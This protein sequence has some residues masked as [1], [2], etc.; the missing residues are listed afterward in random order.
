MEQCDFYVLPKF[1]LEGYARNQASISIN[2]LRKLTAPKKYAE[3][4][5]E[6]QQ[7]YKEQQNHRSDII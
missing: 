2:P 5:V 1:S 7:A 3:L 6:I 4:Q